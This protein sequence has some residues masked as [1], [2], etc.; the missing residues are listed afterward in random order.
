[1]CSVWNLVERLVSRSKTVGSSL[2]EI[3]EA[4]KSPNVT[5]KG[6]LWQHGTTDCGK[7]N[8]RTYEDG[9]HKLSRRFRSLCKD[10]KVPF[11]I[12]QMCQTGGWSDSEEAIDAA[13]SD[14]TTNSLELFCV[15]R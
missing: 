10:P 9:L 2:E 1:M 14:Y 4:L 3:Q 7:M 6:I 11:L 13:E 5:L 15:L 8:A 12:G